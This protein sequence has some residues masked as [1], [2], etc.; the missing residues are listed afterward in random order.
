MKTTT[1]RNNN[2]I[3][4][5][6]KK[7]SWY[8]A[9]P[10]TL[11][12]QLNG[13]LQFAMETATTKEE[14]EGNNNRVIRALICPHAGYS[15]SGKTAG[16][17]YCNIRPEAIRTI[18]ILGPSHHVHLSNYGCLTTTAQIET[19]LGN[20]QVDLEETHKLLKEAP[21]YFKPWEDQQDDEEEHSLEM[22]Y[23]YIYVTFKEYVKNIKVV[24]ICVGQLSET[25]EQKMAQALSSRFSNRENLFIFSSDF[26]HFGSRFSY[27]KVDRTDIPIHESIKNLDFRGI[28]IIT[29]EKSHASFAKYLR[30]TKNTICGRHPIGVLLALMEIEK[31]VHHTEMDAQLFYYDQSSKCTSLKDSSVSYA[32]IGV[33][34]VQSSWNK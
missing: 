17:S 25:A 19:P 23:P 30:E 4:R 34:S 10:S 7:G 22:Q 32:S 27:N 5:A 16:F 13:W 9:S 1:T 26:C 21:A 6:A 18:Y 3:R 12:N 33:Y 20:L 24:C 15:Y 2:N 31:S 28:D 14:G 8:E 11:E 29:K